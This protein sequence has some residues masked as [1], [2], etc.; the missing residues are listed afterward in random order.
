MSHPSHTDRPTHVIVIASKILRTL[1]PSPLGSLIAVCDGD[2]LTQREISDI[3]GRSQP[4]VS[5]YFQTFESLPVPLTVKQGQRNTITDTGE[6]VIA[7]IRRMSTQLKFDLTSIDWSDEADRTTVSSLLSPLHDSRS[8]EPFFLLDSLYARSNL[9]SSLGIPQPVWFDD[10]IHDV[11]ARHHESGGSTTLKQIRQTAKRFTDTGALTFE[12]NQ[13]TLEEK[14]QEQAKLLTKLVQ[15]LTKQDEIDIDQ[16]DNTD[17]EDTTEPSA[18]S[19]GGV[20]AVRSDLDD[21]P[22]QSTALGGIANQQ[23]G[24]GFSGARQSSDAERLSV[25]ERPTV[26]LT[27]CL[28]PTDESS[29]DEKLH[30]QPP[31]VLLLTTLTASELAGRAEQVVQEYG[32]DTRLVPYWA[33]QTD[34]DLYPLGPAGIPPVEMSDF[35]G[36]L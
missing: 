25:Q 13:L 35:E 5:N 4:A 34:T 3:V 15:F 30:S 27:Y 1:H 31:P 17:R 2:G 19:L 23:H 20:D 26:V 24:H 8:T 11:E 36:D 32:E 33:L 28:H 14:G 12:E 18:E 6:K 10:V 29:I 16:N 22:H 7:L 21:N 9:D